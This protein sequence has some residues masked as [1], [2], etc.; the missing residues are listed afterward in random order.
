MLQTRFIA[1][2][3]TLPNVDDFASWLHVP[4]DCVFTFTQADRPVPLSIKVLSF[5]TNNSNP[6][7]FDRFLS[8]KLFSLIK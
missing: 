8:F 4:T 7:A 3:G 5:R 1:I 6:Y 2:S